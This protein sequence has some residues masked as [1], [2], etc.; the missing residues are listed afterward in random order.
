VECVR[1]K[2]IYRQEEASR[3]VTNA[4][5]IR[6]GEAPLLPPAGER[7]DFLLVERGDATELAA[8]LQKLV[9]ERLPASLNADPRS[10]IQVLVPMHRGTLGAA[11][12]NAALQE[13]L[14]PAGSPVP[15]TALRVGDKVMQIRNNY[16]LEVFNGDLGLVTGWNEADRLLSV[17]FDDTIVH[18]EAGDLSQLVLAYACTVHKSQG[19]EYPIVVLVLHRQ[20]Y[21]MLQRNLLYTAVTRAR[22][23]VV[24]LGERRALST[25]LSNGAVQQ[26]WTRL[27]ARLRAG[28]G[29]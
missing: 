20:H 1:L 27:A 22:R 4:H 7:A 29:G 11:A 24:L 18:Y 3:I 9:A 21:V 17:R 25:A 2:E 16:D 12:L 5:R 23:Q 28:V 8:T 15:G 6:D 10:D 19:S 13:A 26:R 14:N